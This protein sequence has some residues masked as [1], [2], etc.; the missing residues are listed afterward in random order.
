MAIQVKRIVS[1]TSFLVYH[2][3]FR[4][5]F[6]IKQIHDDEDINRWI[7]M[8]AHSNIVTAFESFRDK[9]TGFRFQMTEMYNGGNMFDYIRSLNLDLS[10]D[11]TRKYREHVFDVAIQVATG[12]DA[13]HNSGLVHGNFDLS[14]VV[15]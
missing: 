9:E 10:L 14:K 4:Q 13:A 6:L 5:D 3:D 7:D 8:H 11:V 2:D 1:E 15:I 12:M